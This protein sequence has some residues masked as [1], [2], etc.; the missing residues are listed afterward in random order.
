VNALEKEFKSISES[1]KTEVA[2]FKQK[3]TKDI[4]NVL[5]ALVSINIE[6]HQKIVA[7]WKELLSELEEKNEK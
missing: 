3:K 6:H 5:R 7:L 4:R 1:I 2:S